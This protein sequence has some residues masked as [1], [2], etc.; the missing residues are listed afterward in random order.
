MSC[1]LTR[2]SSFLLNLTLSLPK[3]FKNKWVNLPNFALL[4]F[5]KLWIKAHLASRDVPTKHLLNT[6]KYVYSHLIP[7]EMPWLVHP[8]NARIHSFH[9][10]IKWIGKTVKF[11]NRS[12]WL[13][14]FWKRGIREGKLLLNINSKNRMSITGIEILKPGIP[15]PICRVL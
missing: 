7:L 4:K 13:F 3:S 2:Y 12:T 9:S 8:K 6:Q 14:K 15:L 11:G 10:G 5:L 1:S